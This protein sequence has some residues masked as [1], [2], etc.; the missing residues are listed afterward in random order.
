MPGEAGKARQAMGG[1]VMKIMM[2][3]SGLSQWSWPRKAELVERARDRSVGLGA[4]VVG[5]ALFSVILALGARGARVAIQFALA[6]VVIV[7]L[8]IFMFSGFGSAKLAQYLGWGMWAMKARGWIDEK[9]NKVDHVVMRCESARVELAGALWCLPLLGWAW[10]WAWAVRIAAAN[11]LARANSNRCGMNAYAL[12]WWAKRELGREIWKEKDGASPL[13]FE[14]DD[15]LMALSSSHPMGWAGWMMGWE[16][17]RSG[18]SE[19]RSRV[20]FGSSEWVDQADRLIQAKFL[21]GDLDQVAK[22]PAEA[23]RS[24]RRI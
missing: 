10:T 11:R 13:R 19:A 5:C 7:P 6:I 24:S 23:A 17:G 20:M 2:K 21:R 1:C 22:S 14:P 15:E 16:W 4:W 9:G 12:A 8:A 3:I 18:L